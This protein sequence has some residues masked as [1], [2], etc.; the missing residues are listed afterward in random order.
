MLSSSAIPSRDKE[1]GSEVK[2][3]HSSSL[4]SGRYPPDAARCGFRIERVSVVGRMCVCLL[5]TADISL[6]REW[7]D[8]RMSGG[9]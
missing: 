6:I 5:R 2:G 4:E 1:Q 3:E 9:G 7:T 8:G